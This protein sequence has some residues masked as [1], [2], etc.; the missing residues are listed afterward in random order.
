MRFALKKSKTKRKKYIF[1]VDMKTRRVARGGNRMERETPGVKDSPMP[2]KVEYYGYASVPDNVVAKIKNSSTLKNKKNNLKQERKML[3]ASYKGPTNEDTREIAREI[4]KIVPTF[5]P[6]TTAYLSTIN[7]QTLLNIHKNTKQGS[8]V[9][10]KNLA[11]TFEKN[12]YNGSSKLV[13]SV[14]EG[15]MGNSHPF[16]FSKGLGAHVLLESIKDLQETHKIK[17]IILVPANRKLENYYAKFGFQIIEGV[18]DPQFFNVTQ[19]GKVRRFGNDDT[20]R[21]MVKYLS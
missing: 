3:R 2:S 10:R 9:K 18:Q 8:Y 16:F 17:S 13:Y 14:H 7:N 21:I 12:A 11:N 6:T 19:S 20:G 4:K 1:Y 15:N 5:D